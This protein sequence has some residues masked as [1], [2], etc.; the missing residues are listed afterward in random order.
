MP[1]RGTNH[2]EFPLGFVHGALASALLVGFASASYMASHLGFGLPI[3]AMWPAIVQIHGHTQLAGWLGLFIMGVSLHVLPRLSGVPLVAPSLTHVVWIAMLASL[4]WRAVAQ[5][6]ILIGLGGPFMVVAM[7]MAG[8][9]QI[10]AVSCYV[11]LMVASLRASRIDVKSHPKIGPLRPLLLLSMIS[12]LGFGLVMGGGTIVSG[13][14]GSGL[15]AANLH[16]WAADLFIAGV[17][18]P[19]AFTFSIRLFPLYLQIEPVRWNPTRFALAYGLLTL[20]EFG[21]RASVLAMPSAGLFASNLA[22]MVAPVCGI[23]RSGAILLFIFFL[24]LHRRRTPQGKWTPEQHGAARFGNYPPLLV[25]AYCYLAVGALLQGISLIGHVWGAD[26]WLQ[27]AGARHAFAAGFGT[28]LLLG[29]APRMVAG[30][31]MARGPARP[32]W[33]APTFWLAVPAVA[34]IT[35]YLALPGAAGLPLRGFLFGIAG[36]MQWIAV[37]LL[38]GNLWITILRPAKA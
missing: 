19:V 12:W 28:L 3:A 6:L 23:L 8:L 10:L 22:L 38:A 17:L 13:L 16:L 26:T 35:I 4:V 27:P 5:P 31:V 14:R 37:S 11:G 2:S 1:P 15:I 21:F 7:L 32:R 25:A 33:V 20:I 36:P 34:L 29:V 18:I 24:G 30:F 9:A